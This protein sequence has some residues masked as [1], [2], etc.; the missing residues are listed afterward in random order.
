MNAPATN[1][2]ARRGRTVIEHAKMPHNGAA[3]ASILGGVLLRNDVLALIPELEVDDFYELKHRI[4]FAAMRALEAAGKPIDTTTLEVEIERQGKLDAIGGPALLGELA[5][6][7]PTADNVVI[8][9][10]E[11]KRDSRNRKAIIA[12]ASALER[13]QKWPHAAEELIS[14]VAGELQRLEVDHA[15]PGDDRAGK[16]RWAVPMVEFL[17]DEEPDDDDAVDWIVRDLIP[18]G[19]PVI[20]GGPMKAGKTWAVM[21]LLLAIALGESW[22]GRFE[23]TLGEPARVMGVFLE[24]NR[25][26]VSKR[27]HELARARGRD[28]LRDPTLRSNLFISR[29]PLRLPD[30]KDQRALIKEIRNNGVR[31]VAVDNLTRVILGDPNST[32][33]AANFTRAWTEIGDE[34]GATIE[35]LHH[36][37]KPTTDKEVDPFDQLRGSADFGAA[38]R[39]MVVAM[40]LRLEG[41]GLC[42]EVRM[43]GNLDLRV[44]SFGLG[45][46][47][48]PDD[49]GWGGRHCARLVDLGDVD[50]L[51]Q[52]ASKER[53]EKRERDK[54]EENISK[55]QQ[56]REFVL[57]LAHSSKDGCVSQSSAA[58]KLGVSA[59]TL[60]PTF[61]S[62]V[63]DGLLRELGKG[64][65]Y[66]LVDFE[67][68]DRQ[69]GLAL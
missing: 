69:E 42:A 53:K 67:P 50:K 1:G 60:K 49:T 45:F 58:E 23:N 47:R 17:G 31:V 18:R 13:A 15:G 44:D 59:N 10:S 2:A 52:D 64:R 35:F 25:R 61:Q 22:L 68:A 7:V 4:V 3:E 51:K 43:R 37:K 56:R 55:V 39:N 38:A 65:P 57:A 5:I 12:L 24:D 46:E 62:L 41:R 34:T 19:E 33:D 21:D 48:W 30:A 32:R 8:Y 28:L 40:P 11:V 6:I 27:L 14:E 66:Q 29:S 26:R 36:T 20:W 54:R 9:A 63:R 16:A